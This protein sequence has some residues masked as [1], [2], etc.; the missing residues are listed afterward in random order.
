MPKK[1]SSKT[2]TEQVVVAATPVVV[3]T[4]AAVVLDTL[5]I[6]KVDTASV[7]EQTF[8]YF[9]ELDE[10]R[11]KPKDVVNDFFQEI[12]NADFLKAWDLTFDPIWEKKE[13][14]WFV[15]TEQ[16]GGIIYSEIKS[17]N[18]KSQSNGSVE[19]IVSFFQKHVYNGELC[20]KQLIRVEKRNVNI[21]NK[22]QNLWMIT[23]TKNLVEPYFCTGN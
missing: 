8:N 23:K 10:K 17:I 2:E 7:T 20:F 4:A 12:A 22:E 13:Y 9:N 3:D 14:S 21:G 19:F 5:G 15:S 6:I 11:Q 16:Y 1:T 18:E